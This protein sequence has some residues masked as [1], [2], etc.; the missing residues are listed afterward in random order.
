MICFVHPERSGGNTLHKILENNS[1]FH[2]RL[3]PFY[4]PTSHLL[5]QSEARWLFRVCPFAK[6]FGGHCVARDVRY[7]NVY[8][9]PIHY[10]TMLRDPIERYVAHYIHQRFGWG[11]DWTI[12][13]FLND[14]QFQNLMTKKICG[15][16]D[17]EKA[18]YL[19]KE[20]FSFA[21]LTNQF[22]ESLILMKHALG[23]PDLQINYTRENVSPDPG[24]RDELLDNQRIRDAV[25][26]MNEL[27]IELYRF[28]ENLFA[29]RKRE[30]PTDLDEE[31]ARL[32]SDNLSFRFPP[33]RMLIARANRL[34]IK[35]PE[36][37]LR[38]LHHSHESVVWDGLKLRT[39]FLRR[40]PMQIPRKRWIRESAEGIAKE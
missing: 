30:Y 34:W 21:G 25:A 4:W 27:D 38:K 22:D 11:I 15:S 2:I 5:T 36:M 20:E 23:Q 40:K 39:Q 19:I 29:Q 1:P 8:L 13:S 12:D 14:E 31:V 16:N 18:K 26:E 6:S 28:V 17:L 10:V 9:R 33:A 3:T 35:G 37:V 7:E 24:K 32:R